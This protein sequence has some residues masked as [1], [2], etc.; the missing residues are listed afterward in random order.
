[1]RKLNQE[2][3]VEKPMCAKLVSEVQ[4][5]VKLLQGSEMS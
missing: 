4:V 2:I 1:M 5:L 3:D